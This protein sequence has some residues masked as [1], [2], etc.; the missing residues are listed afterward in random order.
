MNIESLQNSISTQKKSRDGNYFNVRQNIIDYILTDIYRGFL[1][2]ITIFTYHLY[3]R[4][5]VVR[6]EYIEH[7]CSG[8]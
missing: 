1:H 7:I 5:V 2:F 4:T 8:L 6:L 3:V